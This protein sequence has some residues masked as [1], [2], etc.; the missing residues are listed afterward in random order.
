ML[1]RCFGYRDGVR[2]SGTSTLRE[3]VRIADAFAECGAYAE[4]LDEYDTSGE[5]AI[6]DAVRPMLKQETTT[7]TCK[8]R[9]KEVQNA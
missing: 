4:L 7:I 2:R 5:G 6:A 9:L 1:C 3:Q 8:G